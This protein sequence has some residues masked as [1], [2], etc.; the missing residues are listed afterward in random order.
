MR[1]VVLPLLLLITPAVAGDPLQEVLKSLDGGS[2]DSAVRALV[3]PDY[4]ALGTDPELARPICRRAADHAYAIARSAKTGEALV[5]VIEALAAR[6]LEAAPGNAEA[7]AAHGEASLLRARARRAALDG[8]ARIGPEDGQ[9]PV[10]FVQAAQSFD[11]SYRAGGKD[12][13]ALARGVIARIEHSWA[14][15]R[16]RAAL[17]DAAEERARTLEEKHGSSPEAALARGALLLER[18]RHDVAGAATST[19][20]DAVRGLVRDALGKLS[21]LSQSASADIEIPTT[22]ND[23]VAFA[24]T[25]AKKLRIEA[26]F[27]TRPWERSCLSAQLPRSRLVFPTWAGGGQTFGSL[28]QWSRDG[29]SSRR[30]VMYQYL[31][32]KEYTMGPRG[33]GGD[34][35]K[36]LIQWMYD[37][38]SS[39][40]GRKKRNRAV[41][42]GRLNRS[43]GTGYVYEIAGEDAHGQALSYRGYCFKAKEHPYSI[44]VWIEEM[45]GD[46]GTDIVGES[47]IES[48]RE[49][50]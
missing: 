29:R 21:L 23:I 38:D 43:I 12:G 35:P 9:S 34:N 49:K 25:N 20:V 6:V 41:S 45:G 40:F 37:T 31:H 7:L 2:W 1:I 39:D 44:M 8:Q 3:Y 19:E 33:I 28:V 46:G 17:L 18:A 4:A 47:I 24:R 48:M 27:V 50:S 22:L 36:G 5:A 16:E 42:K 10:A 14:A 11:E 32:W 30:F 26:E 13:N 15:P